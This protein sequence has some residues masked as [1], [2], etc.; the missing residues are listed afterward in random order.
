MGT[1]LFFLN[2]RAL[3][4][5]MVVI[6]L[7]N[8]CT[9]TIQYKQYANSTNTDP[10]LATIYVIRPGFIGTAVRFRIHD[11]ESLVGKLGPMSYLAWHVIPNGQPLYIVSLAEN[12]D[13]V[14]LHPEPG[15]KYYIR[16]KIRPGFAYARTKLELV[17]DE[18]GLRML[19]TLSFPHLKLPEQP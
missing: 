10:E 7:L 2:V 11:N 5:I 16:Q 17:D 15:E 18:N 3:S 1:K 8:S 6:L 13:M 14:V 9:R 4:G 12:K 19:Q